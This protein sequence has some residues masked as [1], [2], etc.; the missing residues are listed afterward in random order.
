[1]RVL[2]AAALVFPTSVLAVSPDQEPYFMGWYM[3]P[4]STEAINCATDMV[5]TTLSADRNYGAC[6]KSN[7][8]NCRIATACY[9]T[10]VLYNDDTTEDCQNG[11]YCMSFSI[12]ES[13]PNGT[14]SAV[15]LW[16]N[17]YWRA[18]TVYK[19]L[20]EVAAAA[21]V[22]KTRTIVS[23]VTPASAPACATG[24]V[25]TETS[26][27]SAAGSEADTTGDSE[28]DKKGAAASSKAWIAGAVVG[29]V[30]ALGLVGLAF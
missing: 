21:T 7:G 24:A 18:H 13:F 19:Q 9:G 14:P 12:L 25:V 20:P 23:T 26:T 27:V 17:T 6:C 11:S 22:T 30:A 8:K 15:Q 16:C 1:M 4:D 5:H 10:T 2:A 29:P 3:A 28:G